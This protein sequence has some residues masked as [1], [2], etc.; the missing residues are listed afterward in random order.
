MTRGI[1]TLEDLLA[2]L[3]GCRDALILVD[4]AFSEAGADPALVE[5]ALFGIYHQLD[6]IIES[7]GNHLDHI[8]N[9]ILVHAAKAAERQKLGRG[10]EQNTAVPI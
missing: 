10:A 9:D 5:S 4:V 7:M 8:P 2:C 3:R 1:E 6:S